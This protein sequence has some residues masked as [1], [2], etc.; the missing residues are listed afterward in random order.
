[1]EENTVRELRVKNSLTNFLKL[2]TVNAPPH[3]IHK[4]L[5]LATVIELWELG[6]SFN[7]SKTQNHTLKRE[8]YE[9][10]PIQYIWLSRN[11][12]RDSVRG[13]L[14][15]TSEQEM[16]LLKPR[17]QSNFYDNIE[18]FPLKI[19]SSQNPGVARLISLAWPRGH[20]ARPC[21]GLYPFV[22]YTQSRREILGE[23]VGDMGDEKWTCDEFLDEL[24]ACRRFFHSKISVCPPPYSWTL[25]TPLTYID[26]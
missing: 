9:R 25:A 4:L 13:F 16:K 1:M 18:V 20:V 19:T 24:F 8:Y 22:G 26:L 10:P 17:T 3:P 2:K 21:Y 7:V 23:G 15:R 11:C 6:D 14:L 12:I 5:L